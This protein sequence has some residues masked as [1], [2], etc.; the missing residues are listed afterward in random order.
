MA[1]RLLEVLQFWSE[2]EDRDGKLNVWSTAKIDG[3]FFPGVDSLDDK[4]ACICV[5]RT[6]RHLEKEKLK[7]IGR[8]KQRLLHHGIVAAEIEFEVAIWTIEQWRA[9]LSYLPKIDPARHNAKTTTKTEFKQTGPPAPQESV[10]AVSAAGD[11]ST[12]EAVAAGPFVEKSTTTTTTQEI[13]SHA[14]EHPDTDP[15]G[16]RQIYFTEIS[17]PEPPEDGGVRR[18]RLRATEI[19]SAD[20]RFVTK[21]VSGQ[22]KATDKADVRDDFKLG[23]KP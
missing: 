16:I 15:L 13:V 4:G 22:K 20:N 5:P 8:Q 19:V 6:A 3:K 17:T 9:Y 12:T 14:L 11:V 1:D 18:I 7:A 21:K 10:V 23:R 2:P